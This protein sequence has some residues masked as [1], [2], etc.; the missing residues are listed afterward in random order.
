MTTNTS[1]LDTHD[2]TTNPYL[3][4]KN[5]LFA[6]VG[7]ANQLKPF[8]SFKPLGGCTATASGQAIILYV[9]SG[10]ASYSDSTGK[11][12]TL[13]QGGWCWIIAG[14]GIRYT[15]TPT[16]PDYQSMELRVALTPA[17]EN[18]PP[19][20]ASREPEPTTPQLLLGWHGKNRSDFATPSQVNYLVVRLNAHQD[21]DYEL[22]LN[23]KFAW[24]AVVSGEVTTT[25]GKIL[26]GNMKVFNHPTTKIECR[27][28]SSSMLVVGSSMEFG[29]D[30]LFHQESIHTSLEALR[31]GLKGIS[32][33]ATD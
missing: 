28:H 2:F 20:T 23:H 29:Y 13:K 14:S 26:S 8:I 25:S 3:Q 30:L 1:P 16:T 31:Q 33:L 15:I 21:W 10:E 19:Q 4:D 17:L 9:V 22:P 27:A 24:V 7:D 6:A 12:G 18:S 5:N 11:R 32:D